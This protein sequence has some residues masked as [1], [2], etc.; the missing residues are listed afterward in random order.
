MENFKKV[1]NVVMLELY[2]SSKNHFYGN[3]TKIFQK[4]KNM[5]KCYKNTNGK[6]PSRFFWTTN[7]KTF[8]LALPD[9][10]KPISKISGGKVFSLITKSE[11]YLIAYPS[12][13]YLIEH[14][15]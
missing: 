15:I 8:L 5:R 14:L 7:R 1:F 12:D 13:L 6:N 9:N 11:I 10:V 2:L 4:Y 3:A